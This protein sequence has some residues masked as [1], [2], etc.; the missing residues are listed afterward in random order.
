MKLRSGVAS[1]ARSSRWVSSSPTG[2]LATVAPHSVVLAPALR[3]GATASA[4]G[5]GLELARA[6]GRVTTATR[7]GSTISTTMRPS[8]TN[9]ARTTKHTAP[10]GEQRNASTERAPGFGN[11]NASG[12]MPGM[13]YTARQQYAERLIGRL[14]TLSATRSCNTHPTTDDAPGLQALSTKSLRVPRYGLATAACATYV[15]SR[16]MRQP[17]TSTTSFQLHGVAL[18]CG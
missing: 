14:Q 1:A 12:R 7:C 16:A 4:I 11:G 8:W 5:L 17:G 13:R 3:R 10:N 9:S 6:G 2:A 15:D 18:T